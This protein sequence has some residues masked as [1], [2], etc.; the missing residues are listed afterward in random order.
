MGLEDMDREF[1]LI[2][3]N[4]VLHHLSDPARGWN[5]ITD[6]LAPGGYMNI[7]VYSKKGR[8]VVNRIRNY[9]GT[10][11]NNVSPDTIRKTRRLI[12][13]GAIYA[14]RSEKADLCRRIVAFRDFYSLSQ[15]RF[16]LFDLP[17]HLFSIPEL[18]HILTSHNL[19]FSSFYRI[20]PA[21][22][23][24]YREMFPED[25]ESADLDNWHKFETDYPDTF[26][27][28]YNFWCQKDVPQ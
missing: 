2:I 16:L 5:I 19:R 12:I 23:A 26:H 1:C 20:P 10:P 4:G 28:M 7:G 17:E 15:C 14:E 6:M 27:E 25:T 24:Q 22:L 3:C 9:L 18:K 21:R 11:D 13:R 8:H